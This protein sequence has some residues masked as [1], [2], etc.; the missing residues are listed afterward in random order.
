MLVCWKRSRQNTKKRLDLIE[1][2]QKC[3]EKINPIYEPM[4]PEDIMYPVD[5]EM[6]TVTEDALECGAILGSGTIR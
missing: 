5:R 1:H 3:H 4:V 2:A 6:L